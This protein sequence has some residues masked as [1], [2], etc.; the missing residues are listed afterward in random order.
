LGVEIVNC[1]SCGQ[2][3]FKREFCIFCGK[4]ISEINRKST[5]LIPVSDNE[6]DKF[7]VVTAQEKLETIVEL[8]NK[9]EKE[10]E[11]LTQNCNKYQN[12]KKK[13]LSNLENYH[14]NNKKKLEELSVL[15]KLEEISET[16]FIKQKEILSSS[17]EK[18]MNTIKKIKAELEEIKEIREKIQKLTLNN[19]KIQ[20]FNKKKIKKKLS[21]LEL[22]YQNNQITNELYTKL[23]TK[24]EK[25]LKN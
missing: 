22:A 1:P 5:N 3:T 8:K 24:Y 23:K 11:T 13:N 6:F 25:Q 7:Q 18:S 2:E 4:K 19:K 15:L 16:D 20:T 12:Q 9:I 14:K 17:I 21:D 10:I